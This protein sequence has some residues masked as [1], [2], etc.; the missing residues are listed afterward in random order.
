MSLNVHRR[1]FPLS[2]LERLYNNNVIHYDSGGYYLFQETYKIYFNDFYRFLEYVESRAMRK[3]NLINQKLALPFIFSKEA[4]MQLIARKIILDIFFNLLYMHYEEGNN[5]NLI[6][7]EWCFGTLVL[8]TVINI[9]VLVKDG[10]YEIINTPEPVLE[11]VPEIG[12]DFLLDIFEFPEEAFMEMWH[13]NIL[14][15]RPTY[16]TEDG[17]EINTDL[18]ITPGLCLICT[19]YNDPR[20]ERNCIMRR[21]EQCDEP[22]FECDIF[23]EIP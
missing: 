20:E 19:K 23:V 11:I 17:E 7:P 10:E 1:G 3:L 4:E 18:L 14:D 15:R 21:L 2:K 12:K 16:I 8:E 13:H 9:E 5:L 22:Y 6:M